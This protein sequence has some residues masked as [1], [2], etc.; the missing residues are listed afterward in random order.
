MEGTTMA[1]ASLIAAIAVLLLIS[2]TTAADPRITVLDF[3][4]TWCKPCQSM[5][6][7]I[8]RLAQEGWIIRPVDADREVELLKHFQ[9][10]SLPTIILLRDGKPIDSIVGAYGYQKL[11]QRFE[12]ASKG[13]LAAPTTLG[14]FTPIASEIGSSSQDKNALG[15]PTTVRG[16]SPT[17]NQPGRD[18]IGR[19]AMARAADATVRIRIDEANATSFGSGTVVHVQAD[20]ALVL[21]CGHLFRHLKPGATLTVDAFA[22]G[23]ATNV[24][25]QLVHYNAKDAD[26]GLIEFRTPFPI[27]PVP[28]ASLAESPKVGDAAFSMGCDLGADPTRRDTQIKHLNRYLGAANVEIVGAPVVGRS[29]GGLFDAQGRLVGVCNAADEEDNEGIYAALP[30]IHPCLAAL[31]LDEL[32]GQDNLQGTTRPITSMAS[33]TPD[34]TSTPAVQLA[35]NQQPTRR[36]TWPDQSTTS[37]VPREPTQIKCIVRDATGA[38]SLVTIDNPSQE[39]L[40]AIRQSA[41]K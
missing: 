19:D 8:E 39:L 40:D 24:P 41:R 10:Q 28:I 30:V 5:R 26:I 18:A 31:K 7:A 33:L 13:P 23:R 20:H 27:N 32:Q 16:Q 6:P 36:S 29:G 25:A 11:L 3:T 12:A 22:H 34:T 37:P 1:R 2:Q 21:T 4:A 17:S 9:V 35:S 15:A 14:N 38:E